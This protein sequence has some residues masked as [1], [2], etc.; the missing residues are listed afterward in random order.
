MINKIKNVNF[1]PHMCLRQQYIKYKKKWK[2]QIMHERYVMH[3]V[4]KINNV[5]FLNIFFSTLLT[6]LWR[7]TRA[8]H[9]SEWMHVSYIHILKFHL[10]LNEQNTFFFVISWFQWKI[11][12]YS[13]PPS[14][15]SGNKSQIKFVS[16]FPFNNALLTNKYP[17]IRS[18]LMILLFIY[19][20]TMYRYA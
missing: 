16:I 20:K 4:L 9:Q 6:R 10:V 12:S 18:C 19:W 3:K 7:T 8:L 17:S 1:G 15:I 11:M 2:L 5:F 14:E 13:S